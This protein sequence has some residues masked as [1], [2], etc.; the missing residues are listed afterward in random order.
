MQI[1]NMHLNYQVPES[2]LIPQEGPKSIP[3]YLDFSGGIGEY[4]I[5][6]LYAIEQK[7]VSMIQ[8]IF[9]DMSN[10][11]TNLTITIR[12]TGQKIVAKPNT[13][14]Y[15]PV[16]VPNPPNFTFDKNANTEQIYINLINVAIP[17]V[18]WTTT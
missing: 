9:I 12:G 1:D 7:F 18:V 8:T 2:Q 6:M 4:V 5:D 10:A 11:T 17:G 13:Q 3:L 14:G 16:L 15:Y